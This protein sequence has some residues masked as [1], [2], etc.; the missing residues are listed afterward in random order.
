MQLEAA[1]NL[2]ILSAAIW[3]ISY[4]LVYE[5][6]P[7]FVFERARELAGLRYDINSE[8]TI[9]SYYSIARKSLCGLFSCVYCM[10]VWVSFVF[11]AIRLVNQK[12]VE[13]VAFPFALSSVAIAFHR[14]CKDV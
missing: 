13:L 12:A 7:L 5:D 14:L 2:L 1:R 3:R 8:H 4:M 6:G 9:P 11:C 10:S